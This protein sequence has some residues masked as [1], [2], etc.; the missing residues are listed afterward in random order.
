MGEEGFMINICRLF[1]SAVAA[2]REICSGDGQKHNGCFR[3]CLLFSTFSGAPVDD[4]KL[5]PQLLGTELLRES[6]AGK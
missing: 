3:N 6:A 1:S 2:Q 5:A 4:P